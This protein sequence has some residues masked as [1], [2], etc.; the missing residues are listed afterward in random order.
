[1]HEC[2]KNSDVTQG[3]S[4]G[5]ETPWSNEREAAQ[6]VVGGVVGIVVKLRDFVELKERSNADM[7]VVCSS[8]IVP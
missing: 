1:V 8:I 4:S 6:R 3:S 2:V 5:G 7:C